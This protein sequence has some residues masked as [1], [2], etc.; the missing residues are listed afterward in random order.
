L[1]KTVLINFERLAI[2]MEFLLTN[3]GAYPIIVNIENPGKVLE[4]SFFSAIVRRLNIKEFY[5]KRFLAVMLICLLAFWFVS[6]GD[7][8]GDDINKSNRIIIRNIPYETAIN[9][10]SYGFQI[11]IYENGKTWNDIKLGLANC[12]ARGDYNDNSA[13]ETSTGTLVTWTVPLRSADYSDIWTERGTYLVHLLQSGYL[14]DEFHYRAADVDFNDKS[15]TV[16]WSRFSKE[17]RD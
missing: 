12:I 5:M 2:L 1:V 13:Y 15:A 11:Q 3:L 7:G 4:S 8:D 9:V 17:N 10:L 16:D 14:I 6:C